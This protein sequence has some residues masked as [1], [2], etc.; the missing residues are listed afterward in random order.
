MM[1]TA[2]PVAGKAKSRDICQAFIDGCGGQMS[3]KLRDGPAFFY[4][5][6]ASN[7]DVWREV[8]RSY[9]DYYYCDNSHFDVARGRQFRVSKNRLQHSGIGRS[10]G[11]RFR[12][13]GA[14]IRP[15][16]ETGEHI[17][18]CP[19]SDH[20]MRAVV[21]EGPGWDG[22]V[23]SALGQLTERPILVR[24]WSSNKAAL[25]ATLAHDL[26]NAHALVTW[27]SAAAV[28][29]VLAGVPIVTMGQCA[30]EPMAG[31]LQDIN[32]L[33]TPERENWA[34]VLADHE[35]TMDEL[36]NGTAWR[37]LNG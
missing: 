24:A 3:S 8:V 27:S 21:G 12:A 26:V 25:G 18:F 14:V 7:Q 9:R 28:T 34:G 16:R 15:W 35:W 17:V 19:Q 1:V 36:R 6:D 13:L 20:F 29:A 11:S 2:Y 23:L 37:A 33:P 31:A 4:G 10:D 22:R 30:A 5:V 32:A